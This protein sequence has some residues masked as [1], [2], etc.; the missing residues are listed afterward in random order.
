MTQKKKTKLFGFEVEIVLT[1]EDSERAGYTE[2]TESGERITFYG[3]IDSDTLIHE[4]WHS[5]FRILAKMDKHEHY[6]AEIVDEVYA[7]S[8]HLFC[9]DVLGNVT[10][11]RLYKKLYD[12]QRKNKETT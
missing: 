4:C 9:A 12:T 3:L 11:M 6:F 1:D 2:S 8:F 10:S 5:F 7:Y